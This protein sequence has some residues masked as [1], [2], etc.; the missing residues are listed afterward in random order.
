ME[1]EDSFYQAMKTRLIIAGILLVSIGAGAA[2][3][4]QPSLDRI[5]SH[6]ASE[7]QNVQ[8][9]TAEQY[10]KLNTDDVVLFDVREVDE[11]QVSHIEGAIQIQPNIDVDQFHEDYGEILDGKTVVFYCSV[12][13]RSSDLLAR[14]DPVLTESGAQSSAN[15]KGGIFNWVNQKN[16]LSGK[17]VHPYNAYWGRLIEDSS[18][19]AY[20]PEN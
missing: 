10:Q 14:L 1:F 17:K 16:T 7:H 15:L 4:W 5:H 8:H 3:L 20:K 12:G 9:L 18:N 2:V 13:R 6:I 11:F 19:I